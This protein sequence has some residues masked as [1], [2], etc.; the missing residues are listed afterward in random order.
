MK[1]RRPR[2][3]R[4]VVALT[5]GIVLAGAAIAAAAPTPPKSPP[6]LNGTVLANGK[7]SL[8]NG[9]GKPVRTLRRGWYTISI[10]DRA[11]ARKFQLV[12]PGVNKSTGMRFQGAVIWGVRLT[13]GRYLYK[14]GRS[15]KGA[16]TFRVR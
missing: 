16:P 3:T 7:L 10:S 14:S 11:R 13:P 8:T 12:G 6:K 1:H 4:A 9:A 2:R 15:T 5:A